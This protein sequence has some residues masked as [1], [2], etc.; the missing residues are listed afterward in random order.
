MD[1][2]QLQWKEIEECRKE[3]SRKG[4]YRFAAKALRCSDRVKDEF[5]KRLMN[6]LRS[7]HDAEIQTA[8]NA[9]RRDYQ[10]FAT[11]WGEKMLDFESQTTKVKTEMKLQQSCNRAQVAEALT[12]SLRR[13]FPVHPLWSTRTRE[14]RERER[15][16]ARQELYVEAE[17]VKH[18]ADEAE[19][20]DRSEIH[21]FIKHRVDA[22]LNWMK[23]VH[24][25]EISTFEKRSNA[26]RSKHLHR[27]STSRSQLAQRYANTLSEL[28]A[29]QKREVVACERFVR[30]RAHSMKLVGTVENLRAIG[31]DYLHEGM[32]AKSSKAQRTPRKIYKPSKYQMLGFSI[33]PQLDIAT[34]QVQEHIMKYQK[35][36]AS[37]QEQS[38]KC[39]SEQPSQIIPV[40][41]KSSTPT[42]DTP[43][44]QVPSV[45]NQ[46]SPK[47]K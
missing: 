44:S 36:C 26:D 25:R 5:E 14:L 27:Y 30:G 32:R 17:A 10:R 1:D 45:L 22:E 9:F 37:S 7:R 20:L 11:S 8:R 23:T 19:R 6:G 47:K 46:L 24:G 38:I 42:K 13:R 39:V 41:H 28:D 35:Q 21:T 18:V 12:A 2:L 15:G 40:G 3:L 16:L 33:P 34:Q 29:C 43:Q 4:K 31:A